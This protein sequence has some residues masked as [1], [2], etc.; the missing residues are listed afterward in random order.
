MHQKV[1]FYS[2]L[3]GLLALIAYFY[4]D[5][6]VATFFHD[7]TG[8]FKKLFSQY[9][10][11]LGKSEWILLGSLVMYFFYKSKKP[12]LAQQGLFVFT[13]IALSGILVNILKVI[14]SRYRPKA[15]FQDG[16]FGF[17]VFAF[18]TKYIFN[19]FPSGHS[20]TAMGLAIALMLLF[21]RYRVL[22]L[23]FGVIVASSRFIITAHYL[24]DVLIGGL[25]GGLVSYSL[26]HY[27]FK[28]KMSY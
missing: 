23:L 15:Y 2:S 13:S 12:F 5:I 27:Y 10:T 9:I 17:D 20:V 25:L 22:A 19:S 14:F 21:P 8:D 26:Y 16:S 4:L 7:M 11:K 28:A 6:I 18:K 24:S 1:F 3:V